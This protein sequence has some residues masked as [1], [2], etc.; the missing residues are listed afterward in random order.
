MNGYSSLPFKAKVGFEECLCPFQWLIY[1]F[2]IKFGI[3][4]MPF[5]ATPT[6]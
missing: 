2:C 3:N 6:P 1:L 5:V 4:V